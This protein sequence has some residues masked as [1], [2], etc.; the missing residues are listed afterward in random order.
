MISK[1]TLENFFSFGEPTEIILNPDINILLG[2]NGSGKS[3]FL[4][5]IMLLSEGIAGRGLE[6]LFLLDWGGF[7]S[8][9]NLRDNSIDSIKLSFEFDKDAIES[10]VNKQGFKFQ[11]NPIYEITIFKSG[12]SSYY[13]KEKICARN[14]KGKK[15]FIYLEMENSQGYISTR[16]DKII[17]FKNSKQLNFKSTELILR[18][19]SDPQSYFPLFTL[20]KAIEQF[21]VYNYF[22]TTSKSIIRESQNFGTEERL[23]SDGSNLMSILNRI[24]NN[25]SIDYDK[26]EESIRKINPN[27]KDINFDVFGTKLYLVLRELNLQKAV[28]IEHVS[29]GTLR[30]LLLLS[31]L[32]NSDR[33]NIICIDEPEIGL[34]PDMINSVAT[35]IKHASKNSQLIIA[36]HSPLLLNSFDLEEVLVFEKN[37]KN[38]SIVTVYN[39]DDFENWND[40]YLVGQLW[41]R[42]LIGGKRW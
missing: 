41:L 13:L 2:I 34:H 37:R 38:Q 10:A 4:K 22:D 35:S 11:E 19:I 6:K 24:K 26:I 7:N 12:N 21:T 30:Y 17:K 5:A 8:V 32:F 33:G 36:T 29:D 28:G 16:E 27:F 9:V 18:Q 15:A 40:D 42:G 23:M 1:I 14:V 3:N 39:K 25:N 20:K 31:I